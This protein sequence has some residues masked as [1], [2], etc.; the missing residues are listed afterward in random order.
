MFN[1]TPPRSSSATFLKSA[2]VD[3][4]LDALCRG[5][6]LIVSAITTLIWNRGWTHA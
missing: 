3:V 2:L 1:S 4:G 5:D 6:W